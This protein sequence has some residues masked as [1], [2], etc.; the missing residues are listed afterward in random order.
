[1][2]EERWKS[3]KPLLCAEHIVEA[4]LAVLIVLLCMG[5]YG[6]M[7]QKT[8]EEPAASAA[9][10]PEVTAEAEPQPSSTPLPTQLT[11]LNSILVLVDST[12]G[13]AEDYV[14]ANLA[15]PYLVSTSEAISINAEAG[16]KAQEMMAAAQEAGI[17][18]YVTDAYISYDTQKEY[19]DNLVS[20]VGEAE[21]DKQGAKPGYNEHQTGLAIDFTDDPASPKQTSSFK[22]T[23]SYQWLVENAH[24][25]GF[26]LRYPENKT[27]ITGTSYEPWH[28]RY[29]GVETA[30]AMYAIGADLT[31]EEYFGLV[32]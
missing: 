26:I 23:A 20:L 18:L 10:S 21:A 14:P 29:V 4:V 16:T 22:D 6:L 9:P 32:G 13:L 15:T 17:P 31:F 3:K 5:L 7:N 24:T 2:S 11:D 27:A 12:H 28:W 19:Y 8:A 1:M 30:E 25:Y